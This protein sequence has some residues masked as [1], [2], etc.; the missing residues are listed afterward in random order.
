MSKHRAQTSNLICRILRTIYV[1]DKE[2]CQQAARQ[3]GIRVEQLAVA[4]IT[5]ALGERRWLRGRPRRV[6]RGVGKIAK[7]GHRGQV[8]AAG[9]T[10]PEFIRRCAEA[11]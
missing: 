4:A 1:E 2:S 8:G 11:P 10:S 7:T 9:P 3:L 5:E 6:D